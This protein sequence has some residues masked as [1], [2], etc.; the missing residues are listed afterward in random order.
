MKRRKTKI[1]VP[2]RLTKTKLTLVYFKT[3]DN[4]YV[5]QCEE[6][7]DCATQ[8]RTPRSLAK[9]MIRLTK[10]IL[11]INREEVFSELLKEVPQS[12]LM[13]VVFKI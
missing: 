9:N 8:G 7:P 2:R 10:L 5:G 12:Q 13:R 4:W 1:Q 11:L 3:P 6:F